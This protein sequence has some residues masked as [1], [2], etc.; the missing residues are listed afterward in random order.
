MSYRFHKSAV[1]WLLVVLGL[2]DV[3]F[4]DLKPLR[5]Y[6]LGGYI[7]KDQNPIEEK[8]R[9]PDQDDR[10]FRSKLITFSDLN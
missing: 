6:S 5:Y 10:S 3:G 8:L 1:L 4:R 2:T 7:S 9:I